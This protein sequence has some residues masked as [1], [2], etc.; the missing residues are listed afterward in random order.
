MVS[1]SNPAVTQ[2]L[3]S[4]SGGWRPVNRLHQQHVHTIRLH[5]WDTQEDFTA[6][7]TSYVGQ[8]RQQITLTWTK[9]YRITDEHCDFRTTF[10]RRDNCSINVDLY[11]KSCGSRWTR[12]QRGNPESSP[13]W[14][15]CLTPFQLKQQ[16]CRD[17]M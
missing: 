17:K 11:G 3:V 13:A 6:I 1:Y 9:Q 15:R 8:R 7:L 16:M 12:G 14:R 5:V 2:L 10:N 4:C